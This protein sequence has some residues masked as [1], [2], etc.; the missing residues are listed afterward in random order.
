MDCRTLRRH[1]QDLVN[2]GYLWE[3]VLNP[4]LPSEVKVQRELEAPAKHLGI[5]LVQ[6]REVNV[7]FGNSPIE[8]TTTKIGPSTSMNPAGTVIQQ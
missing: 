1:L 8:G 3:F 6:Y 7:I 5:T 4:R 2:E